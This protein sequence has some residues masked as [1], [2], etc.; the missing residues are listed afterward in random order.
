VLWTA[1]DGFFSPKKSNTNARS[2][3]LNGASSRIEMLFVAE[4]ELDRGLENV[5]VFVRLP[6]LRIMRPAG[7]PFVK[8]AAAGQRRHVKKRRTVVQQCSDTKGSP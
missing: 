7:R 2:L 8:T 6:N 5:L 1:E 4:T 3:L